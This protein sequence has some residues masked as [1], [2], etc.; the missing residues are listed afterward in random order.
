MMDK[1]KTKSRDRDE[2]T[3]SDKSED[4]LIPRI[5]NNFLHHCHFISFLSK[6]KK[7]Y[8]SKDIINVSF[9]HS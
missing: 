1:R 4:I 5:L 7:E 8:D 9:K 3:Y 6:K 2:T